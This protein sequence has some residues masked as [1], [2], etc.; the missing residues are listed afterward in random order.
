MAAGLAVL[1]T[2]DTEA[3]LLINS[4][5]AGYVLPYQKEIVAETLKNVYRNPEEVESYRRR[6]AEAARQYDW[7]KILKKYSA[8]IKENF[9]LNG[10]P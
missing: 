4:H 10:R 9:H 8:L 6:G 2:K 7:K 1:A 5:Q 3:G